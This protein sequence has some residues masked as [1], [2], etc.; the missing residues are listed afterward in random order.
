V[1]A[2]PDPIVPGIAHVLPRSWLAFRFGTTVV[3]TIENGEVPVESVEVNCPVTDAVVKCAAAG[4]VP[5]ITPGLGSAEVEPPSD[6]EVPAIVIAEFDAPNRP[7]GETL[8]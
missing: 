7:D 2:V 3:D 6:T 5:P 1:F 8:P 4:V